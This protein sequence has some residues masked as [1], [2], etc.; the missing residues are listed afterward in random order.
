MFSYGSG[1]ASSMFS[2]RVAGPV[3]HIVRAADVL[4]RLKARAIDS[5]KTF[6]QVM[7]LREKEHNASDYEP[8]GD[9]DKG[10]WP[11][12]FYLTKID[13]MYRRAYTRKDVAAA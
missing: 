13:G 7:E 2:F 8:K 6:E 1:L 10:L 11:G 3:S 12:T 4:A 5:P 9:T